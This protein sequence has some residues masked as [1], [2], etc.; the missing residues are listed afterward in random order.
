MSQDKIELFAENVRK[1]GAELFMPSS[2]E[3]FEEVI[4][5]AVSGEGLIYC[6][7]LTEREK[8]AKIPWERK[9]EDYKAASFCVQEVQ[10]A[11][12]ETGSLVNSS[13]NGKTVQAGLAP[14]HHVAIISRENILAGI[15][16]LFAS[17]KGELPTNISFET[18]PSRTADIELTLT[19]GVHGP[20]RLT[21][22]VI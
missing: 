8:A 11:V 16:E 2:P 6:P 19:I 5:D 18:G 15:D 17:F 7:G 1:V 20:G 12:A 13:A 10:K 14:P 3:E 22:I 4:G 21:V 9:T